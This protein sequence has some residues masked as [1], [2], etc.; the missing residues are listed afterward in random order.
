M[1]QQENVESYFQM[2]HSYVKDLN[3]HILQ[4]FE[5]NQDINISGQLGFRIINI[6][7]EK[8]YFIGEI[9]LINDINVNVKDDD[10]ASI[11][12]SMVGMFTGNTNKDRK[13]FKKM[14]KLNGATTLSHLIRAYVYSVT[15]LGGIP[16]IITPMINFVNFFK[17]AKEEWFVWKTIQIY[18]FI[19]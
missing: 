11:H 17:N 9:E 7:E 10:K 6:R 14:L 2:Q 12:I 3:M 18:L 8:D 1:E 13:K 5:N 15:G 16:N 4:K 19:Y